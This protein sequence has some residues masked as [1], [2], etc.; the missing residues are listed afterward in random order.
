MKDFVIAGDTDSLFFSIEEV[1]DHHCGLEKWN[2]LSD[3]EKKDYCL[4]ISDVVIKYVNQKSF[5]EVQR[6]DHN[7]TEEEFRLT[8]EREILAKSGIFVAKKKYT[9]WVVNEE[10]V[11]VDKI[12]T[13]GLDLIQSSCPEAIRSRLQDV[14]KRLLAGEPYS[15]LGSLIKQYKT[16]LLNVLPE[17]IALNIGISS[18][19]KYHNNL[20]PKKGCPYHIKGAI[21]YIK[22][23]EEL[24]IKEKCPELASG[25]KAKTVYTI[26]NKWNFDTMT[27]IS[28]PE[29]FTK[30]GLMIDYKKMITKTFLNKIRMFIIGE[31]DVR[32]SD[33]ERPSE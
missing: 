20:I 15:S 1:V 10:G 25:G 12:Q 2:T 16:E 23:T 8:F 32:D 27:F 4:K 3:Q 29:E 13:K 28:W 17:E 30:A 33:N 21:N 5:E 18:I 7:S 9:L 6:L 24:G 19:S 22:L 26:T 11:D 31:D 14:V